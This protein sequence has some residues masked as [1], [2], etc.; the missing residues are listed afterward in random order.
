MD[1]FLLIYNAFFTGYSYY[2]WKRY[3]DREFLWLS[4]LAS[5]VVILFVLRMFF[6]NLVPENIRQVFVL[7]RYGAWI[8][9]LIVLGAMFIKRKKSQ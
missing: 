9:I 4:S 2:A 3:T 6:M 7:L 1:W 5:L 8:F